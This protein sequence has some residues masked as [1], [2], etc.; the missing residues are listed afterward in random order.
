MRHDRL[1][2]WLLLLTVCIGLPSLLFP[3]GR[4]QGAYA[5]TAYRML[6]GDVVYVDTYAFKP[7]GTIVMHLL[8]QVLFGHHMVSIR[9]LDLIWTLLTAICLYRFSSNL[10]GHRLPAFFSAALFVR[11][12]YHLGFWHTAQTDGWATL[13]V[14]ASMLLLSDRWRGETARTPRNEM[15]I[16]CSAGALIG[17]AVIFKYTLGV[18]LLIPVGSEILR[19]RTATDRGRALV[20]VG[21]GFLAPVILTIALLYAAGALEAFWRIQTENV[22]GYTMSGTELSPVERLARHLAVFHRLVP[23][24]LIA[25]LV[26]L[27]A[28]VYRVLKPTA[29]HRRL[30]PASILLLGWL[31]CGAI[32]AGV[33]GKYFPYHYVPLF[34]VVAVLS[35]AAIFYPGERLLAAV[36]EWLVVSLGAGLLLLWPPQAERLAELVDVTFGPTTLQQHWLAGG[37]ETRDMSTRENLLLAEVIEQ[38]TRPSD[39]VFVFG[40]EPG[41]N[42]L[43]RRHSGNRFSYHHPMVAPW[44]SDETR[45]SFVAALEES[46]P[47]L[48]VVSSRDVMPWSTG[49]PLDSYEI[50]KKSG[51]LFDFVTRRYTPYGRAG[52][53]YI[54]KRRAPVWGE[55]RSSNSGRPKQDSFHEK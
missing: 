19:H 20:A 39:A 1:M 50:F 27:S 24:G 2:V 5:Y 41:V 51:A 11:I 23:F 53:Y 52:R 45:R 46:P 42:F 10:F 36:R 21:A 3:V 44:S 13:P 47:A 8:S 7:P 28:L 55:R 30:L 4:D 18:F 29:T 49:V 35:T 34:P 54:F 12:Y 26:G 17:F 14:A 38:L 15:I 31:L 6:L 22:A 43:A 33:Q 9:I 25:G 16:L 32:S 48:F 37:F 40:H